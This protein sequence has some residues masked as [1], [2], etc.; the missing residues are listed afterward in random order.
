M[1]L[2]RVCGSFVFHFSLQSGRCQ[3]LCG[4][5]LGCFGAS[6]VNNDCG[7]QCNVGYYIIASILK[8][9]ISPTV[10]CH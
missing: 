3:E 2:L 4:S 9:C 6:V 8:L 5:S 10:T 7:L 1:C